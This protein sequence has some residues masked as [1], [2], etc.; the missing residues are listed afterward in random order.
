[1][2]PSCGVGKAGAFHDKQT[3]RNREVHPFVGLLTDMFRRRRASA[4]PSPSQPLASDLLSQKKDA[5]HAYSTA[6]GKPA[7]C[8]GFSPGSL[9][10]PNK[11]ACLRRGRAS[12]T[13]VGA[14]CGFQCDHHNPR[15]QSLSIPTLLCFLKKFRPA[16]PVTLPP[17]QLTHFLTCHVGK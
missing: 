4:H 14:V 1:M 2:R 10:Q 3:S 8:P 7:P 17:A 13:K 15:R 16:A 5:L 6:A 12:A 9:V 11:I